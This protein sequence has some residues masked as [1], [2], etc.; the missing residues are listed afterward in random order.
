[1]GEDPKP[2]AV[3]PVLPTEQTDVIRLREFEQRFAALQ[4][5]ID[6]RSR[7]EREILDTREHSLNKALELASQETKRRLD[8]L[9][10]A[11]EQAR[12]NWAQSLPREMFDQWREEQSK[13]RE[14][15][16]AILGNV[17]RIPAIETR[18]DEHVKWRES[19]NVILTNV[20]RISTI[21]NRIGVI[22]TLSNKLTGAL[23][24]L[25]VMGLSGVL[26]LLL[27]L[28]RLAGVVR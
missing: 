28:L 26:A 6:Q 5:A 22:E 16:N 12:M 9:N 4:E 19:V 3:R 17:A 10:H 7:H 25:G 13:W 27:G 2:T 8:E 21:E 14:S 20:A 23:I 24:L 15:V 11:H 18:I 1:M